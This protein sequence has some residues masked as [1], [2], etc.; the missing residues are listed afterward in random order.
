[1][2]AVAACT[3]SVG[4]IKKREGAWCVLG[5]EHACEYK[6]KPNQATNERVGKKYMVRCTDESKEKRRSVVIGQ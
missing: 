4:R 5:S 1:M 2:L 6:H 3:L